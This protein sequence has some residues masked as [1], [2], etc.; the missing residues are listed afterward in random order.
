MGPR[1]PLK[2]ALNRISWDVHCQRCATA[3]L[4]SSS[5]VRSTGTRR[6]FLPR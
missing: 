5:P 6:K 2:R 4:L 3:S 1:P